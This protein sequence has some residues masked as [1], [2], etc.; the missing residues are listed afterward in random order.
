[1]IGTL[2]VVVSTFLYTG[3]DRKRS[4]PPPIRIASFEKATVDPLHTPRN[5]DRLAVTNP[6]ENM[7]G[8][9]LSTSRPSSPLRHHH[10]TPSGRQRDE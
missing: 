9:G 6:M 4:R 10:R 8:M 2:L 7:K 1:M 5:S 3:A